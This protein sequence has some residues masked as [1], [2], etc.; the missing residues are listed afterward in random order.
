MGN[1]W[2]R[3]MR[4][5]GRRCVDTQGTIE[6][7]EF[8]LS[9][10]HA[11]LKILEESIDQ[12][13]AMS[14]IEETSTSPITK[15]KSLSLVDQLQVL[16][17]DEQTTTPAPIAYEQERCL[18]AWVLLT[19]LSREELNQ[20][21]GKFRSRL[22]SFA[23]SILESQK[24]R[25]PCHKLYMRVM[26]QV[27]TRLVDNYPVELGA[28]LFHAWKDA[29][30]CS[31]E[32][33][34]DV[35]NSLDLFIQQH[36][37]TAKDL[38]V[39]GIIWDSYSSDDGRSGQT[40]QLG[41][42]DAEDDWD[43]MAQ[44]LQGILKNAENNYYSQS[45]W[46]ETML[47]MFQTHGYGFLPEPATP[48]VL[49]WLTTS[50][51]VKALP[52]QLRFIWFEWFMGL[53][54]ARLLRNN[55]SSSFRFTL[56]RNG[57]AENVNRFLLAN[58]VSPLSDSGVCGNS[59][60]A[61]AWQTTIGIVDECGWKWMLHEGHDGKLGVGTIL[62]T[63]IRLASGEWRIQLQAETT[64]SI[65]TETQGTSPP[66]G[67]ACARMLMK[68]VDYC[69]ELQEKSTL[70][71]SPD[72]ILHLRQSLEDSLVTTVE[73]LNVRREMD[74][75]GIF[76]PISVRLLGSLL[77]ESDIWRLQDRNPQTPQAVIDCLRYI[78]SNRSD[79]SLLPGLANIL[80]DADSDP[81]KQSQISCLW[82]PLVE[83]L[84]G[85]WRCGGH[86]NTD[87]WLLELDDTISW[88]SSCSELL[89]DGYFQDGNNTKTNRRR[90]QLS[91][92]V[93][94]Q[95]ILRMTL[96]M[97]R[98]QFYLSLAVGTYMTLSTEHQQP[99]TDHESQVI[100]RALT[101]CDRS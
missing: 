78:L 56:R 37:D 74:M 19:R 5:D 59:L 77:R 4:D 96:P 41:P 70:D 94:I 23:E 49:T 75:E 30:S 92:V 34:I 31:L 22:T 38:N 36:P 69:V 52:I 82:N 65:S 61:L 24:E 42:E 2:A 45:T 83:F 89:A 81:I 27:S 20:S 88:A 53:I 9:E 6:K 8:N 3:A 21:W 14:S 29:D 93:F 99:P 35:C 58:V 91:L 67:N 40:D 84:E 101:I 72:A 85:F 28:A 26:A 1:A 12:E 87:E 32:L 16:L 48:R 43:A 44:T 66:T 54:Q 11:F 100:Y 50:S 46:D 90:L 18:V 86:R 7:L 33:N 80:A 73:Y 79:Y 47:A 55:D 15:S 60:R 63:W 13:T 71:I 76:S 98:Q 95:H 57:V 64:D 97:P 17:S 25:D 10:H 39:F 68:V 51:A 62:T